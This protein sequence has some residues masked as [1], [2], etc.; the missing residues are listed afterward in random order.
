MKNMALLLGLITLLSKIIVFMKEMEFT[1]FYGASL[2]SDAYIV[3]TTIP[4]VI[5]TTLISAIVACYIPIHSQIQ[6]EEGIDASNKYTNNVL[7][8]IIV[9]ISILF[10]VGL[11]FTKQMVLLFASGF[12]ENSLQM[13]IGFTKFTMLNLYFVSITTFLGSYLQIKNKFI[14]VALSSIPVNFIIMLFMG[15]SKITNVYILVIGNVLAMFIQALIIILFSIKSDYKYKYFIDFKDRYLKKM[16]Y[17]LL[18]LVIGVAASQINVIIDKTLASYIAIGAISALTYSKKINM[19]IQ[20]LCAT[21][22]TTVIFPKIAK[23]SHLNDI[24]GMKKIISDGISLMNLLLVPAIV[25][26]MIFAEPIVKLLFGRGSFDDTAIAMTTSTLF[27][28]SVGMLTM[29]IRELLVRCFYS[30]QDTRTPLINGIATIIINIVLNF[31][32]S[33]YMGV[34]GL[35]L[36][37]SIASTCTTIV[38]L[39][40]L[41]LLIGDFITKK[42]IISFVK[43]VVT[44]IVT[45]ILAIF[46]FK[47]ILS[48]L[49]QN[50]ALVITIFT[51]IIIY[52]T[53]LYVMKFE[54]VNYFVSEMQNKIKRRFI[55]GL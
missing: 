55:D 6:S 25:C 22:I 47:Y 1:Y 16:G 24:E 18:P 15:I 5:V 53:I 3:A 46:N 17:M 20:G 2:V 8:I 29:G 9:G 49:S 32:L 43:I 10:L 13:T 51:A 31:V 21:T 35:A 50:L 27:Y 12:N 54:D 23:L 39:L 40:R 44:S 36:A 48:N 41:R 33:Y 34:S 28:Y 11:C 38:L 26:S 4:T 14:I 37:T 19:L 42:M 30:M 45:G 52:F 7:N